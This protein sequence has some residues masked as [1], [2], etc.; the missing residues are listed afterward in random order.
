[1]IIFLIF[2]VLTIGVFELLIL[3]QRNQ[4]KKNL[5][6]I[7]GLNLKLGILRSLSYLFQSKQTLEEDWNQL[8]KISSGEKSSAVDNIG[9]LLIKKHELN[10]KLSL[11]QQRE[12][13]AVKW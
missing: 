6:L 9:K 7:E 13:V 11:Q 2:L 4:Y 10:K 3:R 12:A 1:M 8:V 5:T